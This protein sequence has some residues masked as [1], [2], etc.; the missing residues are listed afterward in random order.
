MYIT[1]HLIAIQSNGNVVLMLD[2]TFSCVRKFNAGTSI[3]EPTHGTCYFL[4]QELMDAFVGSYNNDCRNLSL[5]ILLLTESLPHSE[6][7]YCH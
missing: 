7:A 5:V 3:E 6:K 2:G 1:S 4:C